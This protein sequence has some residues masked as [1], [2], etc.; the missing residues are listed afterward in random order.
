MKYVKCNGQLLTEIEL[1]SLALL[2]AVNRANRLEEANARWTASIAPAIQQT[3]KAAKSNTEELIEEDLYVRE[4]AFIEGNIKYINSRKEDFLS[5][6]IEYLNE[7]FKYFTSCPVT[8]LN[9]EG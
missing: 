2:G 5:T 4:K 1:L 7:T 9:Q 3:K 8:Y 6:E